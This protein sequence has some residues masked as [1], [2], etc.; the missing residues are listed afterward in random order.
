MANADRRRF[1][2]RCP[3]K[4]RVGP[5]EIA[6]SQ[7]RA[8]PG[9]LFGDGT[10]AVGQDRGNQRAGRRYR[11]HVQEQRP[12]STLR[13]QRLPR[14]RS[15]GVAR[16]RDCEPE[17]FRPRRGCHRRRVGGQRKDVP[18][19]DERAL[20]QRLRCQRDHRA[21]SDARAPQLRESGNAA[22]VRCGTAHSRGGH[23][24]RV[25]AS[26][27]AGGLCRSIRGGG[28]VSSDHHDRAPD[29]YPGERRRGGRRRRCTV[30]GDSDRGSRI[31]VVGRRKRCLGSGHAASRA[32]GPGDLCAGTLRAGGATVLGRRGVRRGS[33]LRGF[34]LCLQGGRRAVGRARPARMEG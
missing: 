34:C 18:G 10:G 2:C 16:R 8:R 4:R 29:Q 1:A 14:G 9:P 22:L 33:D 13:A 30:R 19:L 23:R 3:L 20:V 15:S 26:G 31:H 32:R 6:C 27:T 25:R 5:A 24:Q 7:R 12:G 17:W 21:G 28:R 11:D